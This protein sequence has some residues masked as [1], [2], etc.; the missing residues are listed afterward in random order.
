MQGLITTVPEPRLAPFRALFSAPSVRRALA[1]VAPP[2]HLGPDRVIS[3]ALV[4]LVSEPEMLDCDPRAVL[5]AV[6]QATQLGLELGG[7]L[8]QVYLRANGRRCRLGFGYRGRLMMAMNTGLFETIEVRVVRAADTFQVEGGSIPSLVHKL[9]TASDPGPLVAV[10]ALATYRSGAS[11]WE[12]MWRSQL[13]E[14]RAAATGEL[15]E[16]WVKNFDE[17]ARKAVLRRLCDYLPA[18]TKAQ[19]AEVDIDV[20][21]I[22]GVA[23]V[24]LV[25]G[26]PRAEVLAAPPPAADSPPAAEVQR[27]EPGGSPDVLEALLAQV[28]RAGTLKALNAIAMGAV[29]AN[30]TD[31]Q[32]RVYH[33]ASNAKKALLR[34]AA[35]PAVEA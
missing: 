11:T 1:A 6:L 18:S 13:E 26:E 15:G 2:G 31:D 10:Y 4:Q 14:V 3:A 35:A 12:L 30:L 17:M 24:A 5:Y 8:G 21:A 16:A 28:E 9:H 19:D 29:D 7:A 25:D 33:R 20:D 34:K 22:L 32:R 23:E 27:E